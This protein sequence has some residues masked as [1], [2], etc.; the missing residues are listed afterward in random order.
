MKQQSLNRKISLILLWLAVVSFII[1]VLVTGWSK[2]LEVRNEY[3]AAMRARINIAASLLGRTIFQHDSYV[4]E[5]ILQ[6]GK[7]PTA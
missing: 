5:L 7:E 4:E 1:I 2:V 6:A 3:A